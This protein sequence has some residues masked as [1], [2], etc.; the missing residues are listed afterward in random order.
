MWY[1]QL[2]LI[3]KGFDIRSVNYLSAFGIPT[4]PF[5]LGSRSN[6]TSTQRRV[7]FGNCLG[8]NGRNS[9]VT[10]SLTLLESRITGSCLI[11]EVPGVQSF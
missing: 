5:I 9:A 4:P 1:S 7:S 10:V 2:L 6:T 3:S 8:P 11:C